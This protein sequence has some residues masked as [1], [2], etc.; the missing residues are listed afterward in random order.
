M[1]A[2]HWSGLFFYF[3]NISMKCSLKQ[4][5]LVQ[6]ILVLQM[7]NDACNYV[8]VENIQESTAC[9]VK[10]H[11]AFEVGEHTLKRLQV[12]VELLGIVL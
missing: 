7:A 6:S 10:Q 8:T 3:G 9:T 1:P 4:V 2:W 11:K 12:D 5:R